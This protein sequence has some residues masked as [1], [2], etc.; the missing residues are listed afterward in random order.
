VTA[1]TARP[2]KRR[3]RGKPRSAWGLAKSCPL[4]DGELI[5]PVHTPKHLGTG[6]RRQIPLDA[7]A[8][9]DPTCRYAV[10][11]GR[12]RSR[13]LDEDESPDVS[14]SRHYSHFATCLKF[15]TPEQ[16]ASMTQQNG[17]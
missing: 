7:G 6:Q 14:E 4:C 16:L 2:A 13:W 1:R 5:W 3:G 8:N 9:F 11:A 15:V 12:T 10:S 17:R